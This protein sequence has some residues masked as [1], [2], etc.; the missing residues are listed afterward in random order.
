MADAYSITKVFVDNNPIAEVTSTNYTFDG[1]KQPVRILNGG[2]VGITPG[3]GE[4]TLELGI[5][6]P[7]TGMEYDFDAA[8]KSPEFVDVQYGIGPHAV[9]APS[10]FMTLNITHTTDTTVE[11]TV[12]VMMKTR[13]MS[14]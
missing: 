9:V 11:G 5:V 1:Q 12:T 14:R 2:F 3:A 4:T 6:I 10:Q 7:I 8:C 13:P